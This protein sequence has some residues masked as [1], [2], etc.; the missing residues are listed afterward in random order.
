M[1]DLFSDESV[2]FTNFNFGE[3]SVRVIMRNGEPWFVASD[4]CAALDYANP[5]DAVATHLDDDERMTIAN[6]ESHSGKRGGSRLMVIINESGLYA[7]VLRS[8]KPEARKF[9]KWVTS[10]VLPSI[11]KT[12]SYTKRKALPA[13]EPVALPQPSVYHGVVQHAEANVKVA[14]LGANHNEYAHVQADLLPFH[15]GDLVTLIYPPGKNIR[16]GTNGT[17]VRIMK[18]NP[19]EFAELLKQNKEGAIGFC[20][21]RD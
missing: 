8:R 4:V 3:H 12:G 7:L 15:E 6:G 18:R 10:E 5:S 1:A 17:P 14:I 20:G 21:N 13:P 16:H 19:A 9:A 2:Q 11:R